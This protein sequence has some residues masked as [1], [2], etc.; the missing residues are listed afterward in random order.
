MHIAP[1]HDS[2]SL[3]DP[4]HILGHFAFNCKLI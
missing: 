2:I 4:T 3:S 1:R